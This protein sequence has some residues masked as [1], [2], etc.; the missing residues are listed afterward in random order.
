VAGSEQED[1]QVKAEETSPVIETA[2]KFDARVQ[3][4]EAFLKFGTGDYEGALALV[5]QGMQDAPAHTFQDATGA[6]YGWERIRDGI[7]AKMVEAEIADEAQADA[8]ALAAAG[9][10]DEPQQVAAAEADAEADAAGDDEP[11]TEDEPEPEPVVEAVADPMVERLRAA[12]AG[13]PQDVIDAAV[14]AAVAAAGPAHT[15]PAAP[16]K[17]KAAAKAAPTVTAPAPAAP[18]SADAGTWKPFGMVPP[19]NFSGERVFVLP[20]GTRLRALRKSVMDAL[21]EAKR[22]G[23][24]AE[25]PA[26]DMDKTTRPYRMRIRFAEA[27]GLTAASAVVNAAVIAALPDVIPA[28]VNA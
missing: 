26:V 16:V 11:V 23:T 25:V 27:G 18:V 15:A 14:A 19:V 6:T 20:A 13:Q 5:E 1:T 2:P 9:V 12:L 3:A 22:A 24:I 28:R 21:T 4:K 7:M 8:D 10:V 17:P